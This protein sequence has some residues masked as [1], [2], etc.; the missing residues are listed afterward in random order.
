[1][2]EFGSVEELK[3]LYSENALSDT[4]PAL[5]DLPLDEMTEQDLKHALSYAR[6]AYT[7]AEL[8]G[9]SEEVLQALLEQYDEAFALL[10]DVS[11]SFRD[12]VKFNRHV[13]V[14]GY[15]ESNIAKY[16]ALAGL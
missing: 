8:Q 13:Y 3:N 9:A 16:K 6:M 12:V 2:F 1:M 14:G 5:P 15:S 11:A 4:G 10:A 7:N